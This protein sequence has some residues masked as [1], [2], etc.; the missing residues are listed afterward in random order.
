M[1][2]YLQQ[3]SPTV[4]GLDSVALDVLRKMREIKATWK[5]RAPGGCVC[6]SV[7]PFRHRLQSRNGPRYETVSTEP[8]TP[9]CQ[10]WTVAA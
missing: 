5:C 9:A 7:F 1:S 8:E 4:L 10:Q 2:S 6:Q 3:K